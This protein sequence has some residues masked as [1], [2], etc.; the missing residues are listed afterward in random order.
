MLFT[1]YLKE[2]VNEDGTIKKGVVGGKPHAGTAKGVEEHD[3]Y[4]KGGHNVHEHENGYAEAGTEAQK[5]VVETSED[6]VD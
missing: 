3:D 5:M 6:D 4:E 1:L 2:D